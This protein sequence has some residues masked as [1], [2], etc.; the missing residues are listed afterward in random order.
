MNTSYDTEQN[1]QTGAND[2]YK[3]KFFVC[4]HGDKIYNSF[5]CGNKFTWC[6]LWKQTKLLYNIRII[7]ISACRRLIVNH[8]QSPLFARSTSKFTL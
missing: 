4:L 6:G 3:D 2:E 5:V 8:H 7:D 1:E